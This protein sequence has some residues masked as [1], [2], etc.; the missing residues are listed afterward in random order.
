MTLSDRVAQLE[1]RTDAIWS[2]LGEMIST[3]TM[4]SN[5]ALLVA[6]E[7]P[8][9]NNLLEQCGHWLRHYQSLA[10][11]DD[12]PAPKKLGGSVIP[13]SLDTSEFHEAWKLWI[14]D[15]AN[16]RKKITPHA[17]DLQLKKLAAV[18]VQRAVEVIHLAIEKGWTGL[19]FDQQG[20]S[21]GSGQR[22]AVRSDSRVQFD[23]TRNGQKSV[24]VCG[25]QTPAAPVPNVPPEQAAGDRSGR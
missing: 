7:N 19:V 8:V 11:P 4:P 10:D 21:H 17:A 2:L 12:R 25:P 24:I 1:D 9:V 15:R 20:G 3:M 5:Q 18:G 22:G 23:A 16:R 13:S 14:E 6:L